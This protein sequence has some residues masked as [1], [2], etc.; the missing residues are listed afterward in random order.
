MSKALTRWFIIVD[1]AKKRK[2][3]ARPRAQTSARAY[4][5]LLRVDEDLAENVVDF[6]ACLAMKT[7]MEDCVGVPEEIH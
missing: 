2:T 6:A 1:C 3:L 7:D 4:A 5:D